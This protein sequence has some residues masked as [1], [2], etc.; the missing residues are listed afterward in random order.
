MND[1]IGRRF[2]EDIDSYIKNNLR[3][4]TCSQIRDLYSRFF[5]DLKVLKGNSNGFTGLSEYLVFRS[6]YHLLGGG[7]KRENASG[8]H[9]IYEF[10][11]D[12]LR[13]GQS[14]P[15]YINERRLY[16]DI[17]IYHSD[18]L[19]AIAQIKIYITN[20]SKEVINE[21]E[22]MKLLRR[23]FNDM[24][25]LLIIYELSKGSKINNEL[26]KLQDEISWF[27]FTILNKNDALISNILT[28][29]LGISRL[30]NFNNI[31]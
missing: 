25:A 30:I 9:W 18:K 27:H 28:N 22:K 29:K 31:E 12:R 20:V 1:N 11:K 7:F 4:L 16:P 5:D 13:I 26:Q 24:Y 21:I 17:A 6:L 14:I 10:V 23:K 8:S 19:K 15:I 3:T 2:L